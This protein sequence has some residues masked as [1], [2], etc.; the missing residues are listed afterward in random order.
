MKKKIHKKNDINGF[1]MWIL[2]S[3]VRN[4]NNKY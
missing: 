2:I 3:P 1:G 4:D